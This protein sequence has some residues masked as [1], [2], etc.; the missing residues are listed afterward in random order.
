MITHCDMCGTKIVNNEC[1][2]GTWSSPEENLNN[3]YKLAIEKFHEEKRLTLSMDAPHL[4]VACVLFRGDYL[5]TQ[6]VI[7][8]ILEI[9]KRPYYDSTKQ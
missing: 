7:Q 1:S 2:C 3:P 9:K 6:K 5:D 4:G 8:F